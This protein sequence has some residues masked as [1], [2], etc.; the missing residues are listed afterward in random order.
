MLD[1]EFCTPLE[2]QQV[3]IERLMTNNTAN[4]VY[5]QQILAG[6]GLCINI[7]S[8]MMDSE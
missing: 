5:L 6:R 8:I 2:D 3:E 1:N 4:L 7:D